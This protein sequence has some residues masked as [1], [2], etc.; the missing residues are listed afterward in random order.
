MSNRVYILKS[1]VE[2]G[3]YILEELAIFEEEPTL[4]DLKW[5]VSDIVGDI[6]KLDIMKISPSANGETGSTPQT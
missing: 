1:D 2:T 4:D 5:A 6:S 3:R